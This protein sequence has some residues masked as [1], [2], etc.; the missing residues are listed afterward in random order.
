M[1][2]DENYIE[3]KKSLDA[4]FPNIIVNIIIGF[5][6]FEGKMIFSVNKHKDYVVFLNYLRL[7][8][9]GSIKF[10]E[11]DSFSHDFRLWNLYLDTKSMNEEKKFNTPRIPT[12]LCY[13]LLKEP[14]ND[15]H[16]HDEKSCN[17]RI[18]CG[19]T[20]FTIGVLNLQKER[21]DTI[22]IGHNDRIKCIDVLPDKRIVSSANK[23]LKIWNLETNKCD[24]TI[25]KTMF[26]FQ[27]YYH[28][29]E[30]TCV[31]YIQINNSINDYRVISGSEDKTLRIWNPHTG[32]CQCVLKGHTA[33]IN[34]VVVTPNRV[35]VSGS[36][37]HTLRLWNQYGNCDY[38]LNN[39]RNI[40]CMNIFSDEYVI[41]GSKGEIRIWNVVTGKCERIL[42]NICF[43][44]G[45]K[46][47]E[48]L[49]DGRLIVFSSDYISGL[50]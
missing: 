48:V 20:D 49:S 24:I 27:S 9:Y 40:S 4:H 22:F 14:N 10:I 2:E 7:P 13:A 15:E 17:C 3:I 33:P 31:T 16:F 23:T 42:K 21:F 36:S 8:H 30:I 45:I 6:C 44:S 12:I 46:Q 41:S 18:V 39:D 43:N 26:S 38:I 28:A 29:E 35:I 19:F 5:Y 50:R 47:I 25:E 34:C 32:T 1:N 37:D 11:C